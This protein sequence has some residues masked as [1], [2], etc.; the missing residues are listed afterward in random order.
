MTKCIANIYQKFKLRFCLTGLVSV[1][2]L[3]CFCSETLAQENVF[4]SSATDCQVLIFADEEVSNR[5]C[6]VAAMQEKYQSS[7]YSC[8]IV[9]TMLEQFMA[10]GIK[11]YSLCSDAGVKILLLASALWLAFFVLKTLASLANVEPISIVDQLLKQLFKVLVAY[12]VIV[13][14]TNTFINY[15]V[16][17]ILATGA[18]FGLAIIDGV[19]ETLSMQNSGQYNYEGESL[20]SADVMN[21]ILGLT[22]GIDRVVSTNLVIGHALTCH[23]VNAGA[24]TF[25][26]VVISGRIPDIW[27]WL[28]GAVI[29]LVG[30]MMTLALSYYLVDLSFKIGI[31]IIIFPIVMGLWPFSPTQE[32]VVSCIRTILRSAAIL[33]FLAITTSF[34]MCLISESLR[35]IT[36]FY[37]RIENGDSEWISKTF[38]I[39]GSFFL[40]IVFAYFYAFQLL[41]KTITSYVNKFFSGGL[42]ANASPMHHNLRGATDWASG[43]TM[44]AG[45]Y[46]KDVAREQGG[47]A[48][49]GAG[50]AVNA[51][52]KGMAKGGKGMMNAGKALSSSGLGAIVGVPLMALGAA[53]TAGG[54]ATQAAGK[55]TQA[56][57]SALKKSKDKKQKSKRKKEEQDDNSQ[58]ENDNA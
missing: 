16:N 15:V 48:V 4:S 36:E 17:P 9:K 7:C 46:A 2:F 22:E 14:G 52:G 18:D 56:A 23:S 29:W 42:L 6:H 28:C 32:K 50:K 35:D 47:R 1:L 31:S 11:T 34:G 10:V 30:F 49:K 26:F 3:L 27:I 40:I 44:K 37:D 21:K 55:M 8:L 51:A 33:A 53:V 13:S 57:G 12:V 20:F 19:S 25:D 24:W 54:Y 45:K 39:T 5:E 43:E 58:N 41:G 38:E